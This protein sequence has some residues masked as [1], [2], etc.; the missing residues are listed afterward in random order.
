MLERTR[1]I[2]ILRSIGAS[3]RSILV[4][5]VAEALAIALA[6]WVIAVLASLP[7]SYMLGSAFGRI[8]FQTPMHFSAAPAAA[9]LWLVF[10]LS[11]AT[12]ASLWPAL[13]A[14][15]VSTREALARN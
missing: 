9:V 4:I 15:R 14:T 13:R 1:E 2:G 8:M 5:V 7:M 11:L 10:V 12:L 3:H 6:S